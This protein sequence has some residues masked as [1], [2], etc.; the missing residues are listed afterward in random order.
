ME[1]GHEFR[2]QNRR[3]ALTCSHRPKHMRKQIFF[4]R[5]NIQEM[6]LL[7]GY[8]RTFNGHCVLINSVDHEIAAQRSKMPN[9][10]TEKL[11]YGA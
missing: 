1:I 2:R 10:H 3:Q 7:S 8:P 5:R 4:L 11:P 6:R 9:L